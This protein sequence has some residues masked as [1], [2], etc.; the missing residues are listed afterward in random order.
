MLLSFGAHDDLQLLGLLVALGA[1]LVLSTATSVPVPILF[2]LGVPRRIVSIIEGESL[3]N[4]GTAL[5]LYKLAVAAAVS[6]TFSLADA[7]WRLP[8]NVVGGVGTGLA[9]GWCV[10]RVRRRLDDPPVE[11]AIALISGYLAFLPA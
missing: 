3:V 11:I 7:A 4:D 9:V 2:G 5:V 6:G 8:W 1:L 10:R